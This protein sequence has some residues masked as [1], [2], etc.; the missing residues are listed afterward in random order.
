MFRLSDKLARLEDRISGRWGK[1]L[2]RF[3]DRRKGKWKFYIPLGLFCWYFYGMLINSVHLGIKST[4]NANRRSGGLHLGRQPIPQ[5]AGRLYPHSLGVTQS[6]LSFVSSP[7]GLHL[8][9]RLQV[10]R[11]K[12]GFDIL[13]D[14][15]H[16]TSGFMSKKEQEKILLTGP[17]SSCP[18]RF[19]QA[20]G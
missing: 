17:I 9:F 5:S 20:E 1:K 13:P 2:D 18:G 4:F 19:S 11:D 8:V 16:G 12:R 15:T 7:K 14:G 6:A 3:F 10:I